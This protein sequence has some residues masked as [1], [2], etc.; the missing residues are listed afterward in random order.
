MRGREKITIVGGG[1]GSGATKTLKGKIRPIRGPK[2]PYGQGDAAGVIARFVRSKLS[3]QVGMGV[4]ALA[5]RDVIGRPVTAES[6]AERSVIPLGIQDTYE[7][8]QDR[9]VPE[10]TALGILSMLGV[11]IQTYEQEKA[12]FKRPPKTMTG[13]LMERFRSNR[14]RPVAAPRP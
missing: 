3:P 14:E 12:A 10:G 2:V 6:L 13:M 8:M 1:V 5:G 4:S 11:G 9:G 7:A